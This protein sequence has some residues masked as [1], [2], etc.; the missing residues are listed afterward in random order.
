MT[1][2]GTI[3]SDSGGDEGPSLVNQALLEAIDGRA[4][5]IHLEAVR[6]EGEG[7]VEHRVRF[8]IDG[9]LSTWRVLGPDEYDAAV[10]RLKAMSDLDLSREA[11]RQPQDG[12]I[13]LN[14]KGREID[15]R[16]STAP[17]RFGEMVTVRVLDRSFIDFRLDRLG[18]SEQ[19]RAEI[20][21]VL[22]RPWG[23]FIV[24]GP[25]GSG[26]TTVLYTM[27]SSLDA[28]RRKVCTVEDPVEYDSPGTLQM[29]MNLSLGLTFPRLV[30]AILRSDPDVIMVG[31]IRDQESAW[32]AHAA[33]LTGHLVF[34]TLHV[35]EAPAT[36]RRLVDIGVQQWLVA[37]ALIGVLACRLVR[38]LCPE[39]RRQVEKPAPEL[40]TMDIPDELKSALYYEPM[41]CEACRGTGYRGRTGVHELL[42][43]TDEFR[44]A[45]VQETDLSRLRELALS[46]GM[47]PMAVDALEK[48][49]QGITSLSEV[50][51]V[52]LANR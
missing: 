9:A 10:T 33:A 6:V 45:F 4:S 21:S 47:V 52:V 13:M 44:S 26:K 14:V 20:D 30:R 36:L 28:S 24:T 48:A 23:L 34:S 25:T 15:L 7:R 37:D 12:R 2:Q 42:L 1:E 16:L 11:R 8:R 27:V 46:H 32:M 43:V 22:D 40:R 39:C 19:R 29:Q 5:D 50:K 17:A 35:S 38:I 49:R 18:L 51:R 41:G 3:P 31:E